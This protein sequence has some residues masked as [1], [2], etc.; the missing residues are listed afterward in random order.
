MSEVASGYTIVQVIQEVRRIYDL[1][2][3]HTYKSVTE[4]GPCVA[5][6]VEDIA[7]RV[8]IAVGEEVDDE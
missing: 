1:L 4:G 2:H 7:Y 8:L 6:E 5:C 3:H